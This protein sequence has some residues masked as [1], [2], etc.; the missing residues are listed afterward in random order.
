MLSSPV[1]PRNK[2]KPTPKNV[3][4]QSDEDDIDEYDTAHVSPYSPDNF[5]NVG[6]SNGTEGDQVLDVDGQNVVV[7]L[8]MQEDFFFEEDQPQYLRFSSSQTHDVV[9]EYVFADG[10]EE[11]FSESFLGGNGVLNDVPSAS[12]F[13]E[14]KNVISSGYLRDSEDSLH[15]SGESHPIDEPFRPVEDETGFFDQAYGKIVVFKCI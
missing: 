1:M 2:K 4:P 3:Q 9:C 11:D 7:N 5:D 8:P 15:L 14:S 6:V 13:S 12:E 10:E